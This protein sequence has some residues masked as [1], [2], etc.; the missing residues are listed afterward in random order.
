MMHISGKIMI[1]IGIV[2]I[3]L[4]GILIATV[5]EEQ[6]IQKLDQDGV[7]II[8]LHD[9]DQQGEFGFSFWIE[10]EYIDA[11][12]NGLW[13]ACEEFNA[14]VT[15]AEGIKDAD[16]ERF[17]PICDEKDEEWDYLG[18]IKVGQA[19]N[20]AVEEKEDGTLEVDIPMRCPD[21]PY[22]ITANS[23]ARVIYEDEMMG[24][25]IWVFFLGGCGCCLGLITL[26]LGIGFGFAMNPSTSQ[27]AT[28]E[29]SSGS[30]APLPSDGSA[31]TVP[32][33]VPGA[34]F[35]A[36]PPAQ[37]TDTPATS[38]DA[39]EIQSA[40]DSLK[41]QFLAGATDKVTDAGEPE[42]E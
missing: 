11:D 5:D 26:L 24:E 27:F 2:F 20:S 8:E 13:D 25:G 17:Q 41:A 34:V 18:L 4:A 3:I 30:V 7:L 15:G 6:H 39:E 37:I 23:E 35:G 12:D 1:P 9:D 19:C 16:T 31:V 28:M 21:G 10:G 33:T 22:E 32:G 40:A 42:K 36:G 38:E 14:S 29:F